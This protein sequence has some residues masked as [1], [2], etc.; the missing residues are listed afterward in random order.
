L[1]YAPFAAPRLTAQERTQNGAEPPGGAETQ[2]AMLAEHLYRRGVN[3][4]VLVYV[5]GDDR[6]LTAWAIPLP[7]RTR[8]GSPARRAASIALTLVRQARTLTSS[9]AAV[10]VQRAAGPQTGLVAIMAR[11]LRRRFVYSSANVID[12]DYGRL[13]SRRWNVW[14]Y[15]LGIRLADDVVV[16]T[17]EQVE[18]CRR[19]FAREPALIKSIAERAPRRQ[20]VPEAFLWIGRMAKYKLP[21]AYVELARALPHARFWMV[22]VPSGPDAP[23]IARQLDDAAAELSNLELLPPRPRAELQPLV[24]KAVAIVNTSEYEGMPNVLLEGWACGVPALALHHDPD[25]VIEREQLG[26]FAAGSHQRLVEQATQM[27][28]TRMDQAEL[29]ERCQAYIDREHSPETV[30]TRWAQTFERVVSRP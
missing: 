14:L 22:A 9:D 29:A 20:D 10:F 30:A 2:I 27:W 21:F 13:E 3:V 1:F 23:A 18:L 19:R 12:F 26:G 24:A 28:H 16:Q 17:P 6:D 5:D 7:R 4:G 8:A 15:E 25:G 11:L